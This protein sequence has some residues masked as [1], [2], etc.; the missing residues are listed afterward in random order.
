MRL[1]RA[2][3]IILSL[4][5][6]YILPWW[7]TF[8]ILSLG[9][10]LYSFFFESVVIALIFEFVYGGSTINIFNYSYFFYL[11]IA[12]IFLASLILRKRMSLYV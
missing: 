7:I 10:F 12:L 11:S 6:L 9:T 8:L 4:I 5:S 3:Y 2:T 1:H